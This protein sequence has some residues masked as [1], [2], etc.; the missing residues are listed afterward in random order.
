MVVVLF[1]FKMAM[2]LLWSSLAEL[3]SL[4]GFVVIIAS[5]FSFS[6]ACSAFLTTRSFNKQFL[7]I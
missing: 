6:A 5:V 2:E 3:S 7:I 1:D 4:K